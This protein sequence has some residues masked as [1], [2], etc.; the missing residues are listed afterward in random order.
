VQFNSLSPGFVVPV[1]TPVPVVVTIFDGCGIPADNSNVVSTFSNGDPP[2]SL[3]HSGAPGSGQFNGTWLPRNPQSS[4]VTVT[5]SANLITPFGA[6]NVTG[7]GSINGTVGNTGPPFPVIDSGGV[8]SAISYQGGAPVA[9][10]SYVA[11]FGQGFSES[12][13]AAASYPLPTSL[14]GTSVTIGSLPAPVL[15]VSPGQ[16]NVIVSY[17]TASGAQPLIVSR[18]GLTSSPSQVTVAAA[19][20]VII[21]NN[22]SGRGQGVIVDVNGQIV[23]PG[24]AAKAGDVVVVYCSGLGPVSPPVPAGSPTSVPSQ[25]V[26]PVRFQIGGVD[27]L[28]SY[29][30]LAGG[31]AQLY[32]VNAT[33]P[34]GV[35][36]DAVPAELLVDVS[37]TTVR[38]GSAVTMAV[39]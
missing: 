24:N 8:V 14:G 27:A 5:V 34:V 19:Q 30:G 4:K 22:Q 13:T 36:G 15:F 2:I 11:I 16:I 31:Y 6:T 29:T 7:V 20:P 12:T 3:L 23:G 1:A 38:S 18:S 28:L 9:I 37:G 17:D 39:Q 32:Q 10:G 33:V 21:S 25:T 26:Y 35:H